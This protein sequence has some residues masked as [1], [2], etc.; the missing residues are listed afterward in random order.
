MRES[1]KSHT[2]FTLNYA[3]EEKVDDVT[4]DDGSRSVKFKTTRGKIDF[5]DLVGV[6]RVG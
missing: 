4:H 2:V 6:C 3:H 1:G 5:F